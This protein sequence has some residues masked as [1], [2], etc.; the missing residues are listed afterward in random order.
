MRKLGLIGGMSW[1]STRTYYEH[2][3]RGVQAKVGQQSGAPLL[4]ESLDGAV[5]GQKA[6]FE[7]V[8]TADLFGAGLGD[9]PGQGTFPNERGKIFAGFGGE[10]LGIVQARDGPGRIEDYGRGYYGPCQAAA[11]G[12]VEAGFGYE[13]LEAKL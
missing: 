3:N 13:G 5:H 2:I 9:G 11:A 10:L 8:D 1:Y 4:I 7:N 12:F 6:G